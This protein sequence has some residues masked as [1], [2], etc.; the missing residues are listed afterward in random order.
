MRS[1]AHVRSQRS[2]DELLEHDPSI[3]KLPLLGQQTADDERIA[4]ARKPTDQE[5]LLSLQSFRFCLQS[6]PLIKQLSATMLERTTISS[7]TGN[8]ASSSSQQ[9][10]MGH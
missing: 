9:S 3:D 10:I 2:N 1:S 4:P 7:H 6:L 5:Y 8:E